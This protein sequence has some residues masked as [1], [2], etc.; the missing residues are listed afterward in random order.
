MI[1]LK[2]RKKIYA[3]IKLTDFMQFANLFLVFSGSAFVL[4]TKI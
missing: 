2:V 3:I 1:L 4:N